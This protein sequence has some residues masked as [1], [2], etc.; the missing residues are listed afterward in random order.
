MCNRG[1]KPWERGFKAPLGLGKNSIQG[2]VGQGTQECERTFGIGR[3]EFS[4]DS[5]LA[6]TTRITASAA[7][8]CAN[9]GLVGGVDP[10]SQTSQ[11]KIIQS[12][13]WVGV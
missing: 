13:K 2:T 7:P 4:R 5:Q 1:G 12:R 3:E 10:V 11:K 9:F 8:A 6:A